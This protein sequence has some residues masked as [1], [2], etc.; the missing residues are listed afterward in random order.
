MSSAVARTGVV[1]VSA[2]ATATNNSQR[3]VTCAHR[4][5]SRVVV[6]N[7]RDV[8]TLQQQRGRRSNLLSLRAAS[9]DSKSSTA[10]EGRVMTTDA[11]TPTTAAAPPKPAKASST[12]PGVGKPPIN[13]AFL[14]LGDLAAAVV[15]TVVARGAAGQD[16]LS[17]GTLIAVPPFVAGWVGAGYLAGDYDADSP[18]AALWGDVPRAMTTGALTWFSGSAL[19]ILLRN[20]EGNL[21]TF[22]PAINE[23]VE[24][25]GGLGLICAFRAAVA[26]FKPGAAD[27]S[28]SSA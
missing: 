19:A 25:A 9:D 26:A 28:G 2:R 27:S 13:P 24:F 23:Q 17:A 20:M 21:M 16:I 18:N 8:V 6:H 12:K 5:T 15:I 3:R 22:P 11:P 7:R 1:T 14:A 10:V 4:A